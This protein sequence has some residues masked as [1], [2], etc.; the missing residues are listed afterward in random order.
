MPELLNRISWTDYMWFS[1]CCFISHQTPD[2][3]HCHVMLSNSSPWGFFCTCT[4]KENS[5]GSTWT[6]SSSLSTVSRPK[7]L[8][9]TFYDP[10]DL[11]WLWNF[12]CTRMH[13]LKRSRTV[14]DSLLDKMHLQCQKSDSNNLVCLKSDVHSQVLNSVPAVRVSKKQAFLTEPRNGEEFTR[15][16]NFKKAKAMQ[17]N[18][19]GDK[20][21]QWG[22]G[23]VRLPRNFPLSGS[24]S[25]PVSAVHHLNAV[26]TL[27]LQSTQ[28]HWFQ[29]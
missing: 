5:Q 10:C 15:E 25:S 29:A 22:A 8:I 27:L 24:D 16:R 28:T 3:C 17:I 1:L 18:F 11:I 12:S 9:C 7:L 26:K 6:L 13:M 20:E 2:R 21:R 19:Q 23:C 14:Q 4:L